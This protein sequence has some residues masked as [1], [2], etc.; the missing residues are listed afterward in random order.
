M[1]VKCVVVGMLKTNCYI[2]ENMNE[3]LIIDPGDDAKLIINNIDNNKHVVGIII[4]HHHF[5]HIGALNELIKYFHTKEYNAN[6]LLEGT[7]RI[8]SFEFDCLKTPGHYYDSIS[9]DFKNINTM[10]VGDFIFKN[11]IG[12]VDLEGANTVDMINSLELILKYENRTIMPGHGEATSLDE[13]RE[14]IKIFIK[15]LKYN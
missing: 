7:N 14:N 8:S 4:T 13:E 6:N 2:I 15:N 11:S 1:N 3:V 12:R 10:F 5:D 9:I